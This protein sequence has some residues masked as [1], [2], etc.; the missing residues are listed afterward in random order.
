MDRR[1]NMEGSYFVFIKDGAIYQA[2]YNLIPS[3]S[4]DAVFP[5]DKH[6]AMQSDK[7]EYVDS[8]LRVIEGVTLLSK[9][10]YDAY[11]KQNRDWN[12]R[13]LG[14]NETKTPIKKITPVGVDA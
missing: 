13:E 7:L 1:N 11:E 6:I 4:L 10:E 8:Q 3:S 14:L 5:V 2:G 9:E 12:I